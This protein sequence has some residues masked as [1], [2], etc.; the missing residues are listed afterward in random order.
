[1]LN[2]RTLWKDGV[3]AAADGL[4]THLLPLKNPRPPMLLSRLAGTPSGETLGSNASHQETAERWVH[5]GQVTAASP[6][7]G[8]HER[9][10]ELGVRSG[11]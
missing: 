8:D 5:T 1:M 9:A 3:T 10:I 11:Q 2:T 7:C 4:G 6:Y